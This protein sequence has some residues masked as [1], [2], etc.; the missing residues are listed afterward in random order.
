[1]TIMTVKP[2]FSPPPPVEHGFNTALA[3]HRAGDLSAAADLYRHVLKIAP[4]HVDSLHHL[5]L[6]LAQSGSPDA[7]LPLI[8][9]AIALRPDFAMAHFNL[10]NAYRQSGRLEEAAA[11]YREALRLDPALAGAGANLGAVLR[12]LGREDEAI[13]VYRQGVNR[14]PGNADGHYNLACALHHAERLDEAVAAYRQAIALKPDHADAHGNA[15]L[16]LMTLG[17]AAEALTFARAQVAL[18]PASATA[19]MALS[20]VW[21]ALGAPAAAVE[22]ARRACRLDPSNA[23]A[24]R[25]L[26]QALGEDGQIEAAVDSH[27]KALALAPEAPDILVALAISLQE[28]GQRT[29]AR[30]TIETALQRDPSSAAAWTV[31]GRLKTFA[32]GDTEVDDL[33]ALAVSLENRPDKL[34]DLIHLEFTLGKALMDIGDADGA[35]AALTRANR[36]HRARID[37]DVARDLD[38]FAAIAEAMDA[39]RIA[40]LSH[41]GH[42][43]TRPIFIVGM[44]RSGTTLVEQILAS[45]PGVHGGGEMKH[46]DIVLMERFHATVGQPEWVSQLKALSPADLHAL[47]EA[48]LAKIATAAPAGIRITDKMPSHFR[49]AGL[50]HLIFPDAVIIHCRRSPQDTC[51]SCFATHFSQGQDFTYDLA[52]LGAY[53]RA[54]AGLMAHWHNVIPGDRLI[55][56]NY[57]DVV[58]DIEGQARR[59]IAACG[60]PWDEACLDFHHTSRQVRTASV[61]QVRQ[62]L[63]ATSVARW[64]PYGAHLGLLGFEDTP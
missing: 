5:G 13:E 20:S 6:V 61:N 2:P 15:V 22:A 1:M 36:R 14:R 58:A 47:G 49:H 23:K 60:L 11:S 52:E 24:W 42:G 30:R 64:K 37:Y 63:Y 32:A 39:A 18:V 7:A 17:R 26:G 41:Q 12:T 59:L 29:E 38:A 28:A 27:R 55:A 16:A 40:D 45:H 8:G 35:F 53:Y 50:I 34:D 44:P 31:L 48:Y 33:Q 3:R 51:L 43:S 19:H 25:Q 62:P 57:E 4:D 56:V 46:L 21:A 9:R 54:Y 10:G